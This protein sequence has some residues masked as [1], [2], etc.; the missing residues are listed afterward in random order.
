M[1]IFLFFRPNLIVKLN[2]ITISFSLRFCFSTSIRGDKPRLSRIIAYKSPLYGADTISLVRSSRG[3]FILLAKQSFSQPRFK[4]SCV[5][6]FYN[7]HHK[8]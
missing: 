3:V 2:S 5:K 7:P 8:R 1:V 4:L 6:R